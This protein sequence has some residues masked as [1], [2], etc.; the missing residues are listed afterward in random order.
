MAAELPEWARWQAAGDPFT[1]GLEE[2][3]MLL[4]PLDLSLV[5]DFDRIRPQLSDDLATRLTPETHGASVELASDPHLLACDAGAE[6]GALR[7][8]LAD[9]LAAL[10]I[11]VASAG[12]HPL[13]TWSETEISEGPRYRYLHRTMREL[14]RREPT[15][16]L[17][18]HVAVADPEEAAAV[19]NRMRVHLPLLLALSANSPFWQG[20]DSGLASA[21]TPIFGAFPRVGIP[22]GFTSY[23]DYAE[24]IELLIECGAF[25]EPT[26]VWW[27]IRLQPRY[28]TVEVRIMDAQ[29]ESW[30]TTALASLVQSL[31]RLEATEDHADP[32]L[33]GSIEMLD[34][35]R[36]LAFRD[37]V[38][39]ALLDPAVCGP[40]PVA[41]KAHEVLAACRPHARELGC[42][43]EL[44][45]VER[46]IELPGDVEQRQ[47]AGPEPD[48]ERLVAILRERFTP[49][50][51]V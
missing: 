37:G 35:N 7:T 4:D 39:G 25:P 41:E 50:V 27:D 31:V 17:H 29:T 20:R 23:R 28:G 30:R 40:V 36:F 51:R 47:I 15:H 10:E 1:V 5:H 45:D 8:R 18:V 21:R 9:E 33:V 46:I 16:A 12:T 49:R 43:R 13:A 26:F 32:R 11:G 42:E 22:R 2:E 19:V 48:L 38:R 14:A 34:E 3:V 24:S 6:L 44:A